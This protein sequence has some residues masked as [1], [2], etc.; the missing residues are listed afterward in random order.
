MEFGFAKV[1]RGDVSLAAGLVFGLIVLTVFGVI[2]YRDRTVNSSDFAVI[3]SGA[4][5][6]VDGGDPYVASSY[7]RTL[8]R[9]DAPHTEIDVYT[10]PPWVAFALFPLALLPLRVASFIWT[11]GTLAAAVVAIRSLLRAYA[12]SIPATWGLFSYALVASQPGMATLFMGQ[13][14]F[15]LVAATAALVVALKSAHRV[16][17]LGAAVLL[18]KPQLFIFAGWA[19]TR[20]ALARGKGGLLAGGL[21]IVAT[22]LVATVVLR[23]QDLSAWL[24]HVAARRVEDLTAPTVPM[25]LRDLFGPVGDFVAVGALGVAIMVGL[26]FGP[27]T[28][29]FLAVWLTVSV[30]F[31]P[32]LRTY[33]QV[34][35]IVPLVITTGVLVGSSPQVATR[36]AILSTTGFVLGSI[37]LYGV[38]AARER[39]DTSALV[40]ICV[41]ALVT[42]AAWGHR[43]DGP[44]EQPAIAVVPAR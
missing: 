37:L 19:Y 11:F 22:I 38:A 18:G 23:F 28:D 29:A 16:A 4:R 31:A 34:L 40:S 44:G 30:L 33:D 39:E 43:A 9:Y 42:I 7:L 35:L 26:R 2:D 10:Y 17:A 12:L 6:L 1:S 27:R 3:W 20:A 24:T 21:A 5:T 41:F 13:W 32:Y 8:D 25:V 14:G 15:L 36:F